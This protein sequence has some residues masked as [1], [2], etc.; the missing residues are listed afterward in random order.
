M[1]DTLYS[2]RKEYRDAAKAGRVLLETTFPKCFAGRREPK[3]P[4]AIGIRDEIFK[5]LPG[6][7]PRMIRAALRDYTAGQSYLRNFAPGTPRIDLDGN[8]VDAITLDAAIH[9]AR[10][11]AARTGKP[12]SEVAQHAHAAAAE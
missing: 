8:R 3:T 5:R 6:A 10:R 12:I 9:A 7:D 2:T 1:A 11:L 4:L